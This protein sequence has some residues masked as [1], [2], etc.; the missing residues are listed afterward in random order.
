MTDVGK[1]ILGAIDAAL[2]PKQTGAPPFEALAATIAAMSGKE[3]AKKSEVSELARLQTD[4]Q[5]AWDSTFKFSYTSA[6]ADWQ[7]HL[8]E[9]TKQ[10]RD[11]NLTGNDC[12]SLQDFASDYSSRQLAA[13]NLLTQIAVEAANVARPIAQ[14]F[15]KYCD[16]LA[17]E[18]EA[19]HKAQ[20]A[21]FGWPHA[22]SELADAIRSCGD[23]AVRR[24]GG[25]R[26]PKDML[27]Y[28]AI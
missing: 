4:Y 21:K 15:K 11:G 8:D 19:G 1:Q 27:P 28:I 16:E 9:M 20:C 23:S 5:A 13:K 7:K 26:A 25:N 14:R 22:G 2:S 18:I 3:L 6:K 17:A 10:I 24:C 12:W